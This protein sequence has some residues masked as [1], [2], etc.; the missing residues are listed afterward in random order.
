MRVLIYAR[1]SR[2]RDESTSIERQLATCREEAERRGWTVVGEFVDDGVSGA[3][4]LADRPGMSRL[5]ARLGDADVILVW[6]ID[7]LARSFLA[8]A[9][10]VRQC[11]A[12]GVGLASASE[13]LDT[14]SAL[15]RAMVQLIAIF[16]ELERAMIRERILAS[17]T[18]LRSAGRHVG[19][20]APYGLRIVP[21]PDGRG[22]VLER[23]PA[24]VEVIREI[25]AR[26]IDGASGSSIAADLQ[27]RGV[28]SPRV[29]KS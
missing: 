29:Y 1:L 11:E 4:D 23:D 17:K 2:A 5:L 16:A 7:R 14:T 18:Y 21:A 28:P 12:T 24:A 6:K 25:I 22:K 8:F 10:L 13:P 27:R 20:P 19:G 3:T 15:G 9:D 26:L